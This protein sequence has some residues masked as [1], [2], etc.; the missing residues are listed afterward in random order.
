MRIEVIDGRTAPEAELRALYDLVAGN[1]REALPHWEPSSWEAFLG[2]ARTP[3]EWRPTTRWVARDDAGHVVGTS[4]LALERRST[5]R[6]HAD[7]E[8]DVHP[9][10][11]R[12]GVGRAL[13]GVAAEEAAAERCTM[14]DAMGREG[15]AL[16]FAEALGFAPKLRE[17]RSGV[18]LD[19]V[20]P[21]L[22]EKWTTPV[23]GYE[24]V[25]FDDQYPVEWLERLARAAG[26]MNTAPLDDFEMEPEVITPEELDE[27]QATRRGRGTEWTTVVAVHAETGEVAGYT[28]VHFFPGSAAGEQEDTGVWPEHRNQGLGRWLKAA[29]LLHIMATRPSVRAVETWNAGSNDAMLHINVELG[30]EV[31]EWWWNLQGSTEVVLGRTA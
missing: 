26:V 27:L 31:L 10:S 25:V 20:D 17:R 7:I 16:A 21:T 9:G 11:R 13:A 15:S 8:V 6:D 24:L 4:T 12:K 5:N 18:R 22:L 1:E 29:M 14:L 30:F 28:E 23:P 19:A 3:L 2:N